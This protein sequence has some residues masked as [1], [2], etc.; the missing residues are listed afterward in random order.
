[1]FHVK[2]FCPVRAGN[3]TSAHTPR[4][5]ETC[6]IARKIGIFELG[7][8]GRAPRKRNWSGPRQRDTS[9]AAKVGRGV[10]RCGLTPL[11][12]RAR[13]DTHAGNKYRDA[14]KF[15]LREL[16]DVRRSK[17]SGF[18]QRRLS[19]SDAAPGFQPPNLVAAIMS[20]AVVISD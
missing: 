1:M 14:N 16:V 11:F 17:K 19:V 15:T 13:Q 4:G 9:N 5:F 7:R 6:G 10:A 12:N 8:R 18:R 20:D 3:L 2:H